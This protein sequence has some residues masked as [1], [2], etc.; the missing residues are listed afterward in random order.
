MEASS[1]AAPRTK[2]YGVAHHK[3]H[4]LT[5]EALPGCEKLATCLVRLPLYFN[6]TAAEQDYVLE[7]ATKILK[8]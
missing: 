4:G 2:P 5:V 7:H 6:M 1:N 3:R 8:A